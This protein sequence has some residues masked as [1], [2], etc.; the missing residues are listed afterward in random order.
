MMPSWHEAKDNAYSESC[1]V[2]IIENI[3][4]RHYHPNMEKKPYPSEVQDRFIVRLPDGMR[5]RIAVEAKK[6]NRSMNAE[7]VARLEQSFDG[8]V[9]QSDD[10]VAP[11]LH[12]MDEIVAES[13]ELRQHLGKVINLMRESESYDEFS[14]KVDSHLPK[15][16]TSPPP[17]KSDYLDLVRR[18]L[19]R[20]ARSAGRKLAKPA[21]RTPLA[22]KHLRKKK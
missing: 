19:D 22:K 5:D 18:I 11:L 13:K 8:P 7:I 12:Q 9:K 2:G 21:P 20:P 1:Q 4:S 10:K 17:V 15:P 14:Q 16:V 3:P 6:N